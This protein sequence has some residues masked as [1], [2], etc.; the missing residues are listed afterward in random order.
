MYILSCIRMLRTLKALNRMLCMQPGLIGI[1]KSENQ[2]TLKGV[3]VLGP[4]SGEFEE[5]LTGDALTFMSA[6]SR[7]FFRTRDELLLF[8]SERQVAIDSG[9]LPTFLQE[10]EFI[11][12]ADWRIL[13][14]PADLQRRHVEITGP[15]GDKKMVVNA[16]NSGADVY[17]SDFEDSQSPT[18]NATIQG[19]LNL[20]DVIRRTIH[21]ESPEGK[22]YRLDAKTASRWCAQEGGICW[23]DTFS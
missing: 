18:W 14:E 9:E 2:A 23:R 7:E 10:T 8:R 19:Q 22:E 16:L 1:S 15:S 3:R 17:M 21:C 11:R 5:I 12:N 6:L 4:V 13:L 20:R